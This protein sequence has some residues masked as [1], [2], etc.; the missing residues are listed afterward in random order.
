M[1]VVMCLS[2]SS[3][4]QLP[5]RKTQ[6]FS[7]VYYQYPNQYFRNGVKSMVEYNMNEKFNLGFQVSSAYTYFPL[8]Y[9]SPGNGG[10][11]G[12]NVQIDPNYFNDNSLK[13]CFK[14]Y[15]TNYS[16]SFHGYYLGVSAQTGLVRESYFST[17]GPGFPRYF[18][19]N[20]YRYNRFAF[21]LGRQWTL[22]N[23]GV[24]D[25]NLGVGFN[26]MDNDAVMKFTALS[27]FHIHKNTAFFMTELAFGIGTKT[28][29]QTLPNKPRLRDSL[30]LDEALLID[31]NAILNAGIELNL[32]HSNVN[33]R[34]LRNYVRVRN[35][36][37][38]GINITEADSF[39]SIMVGMQ[40]RHYPM[41]TDYR[42]GVYFGYGYSYEHS[43]AFYN[44]KLQ[45]SD[46]SFVDVVKR[47]QYD[48][49]NF[50]VTV[51][52]TTIVG[53]RYILDGYVS[54]I[55]T[56]SKGQGA[57]EFPRINDA[58]GFRTE[59]G[60]KMGIARFKRK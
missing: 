37:P 36:K 26:K 38:G 53:H 4:G 24:V 59:L 44:D 1:V 32:Y 18:L 5:I 3:K 60:F 9:N 19:F 23:E 52:F 51:G 31:F 11:G 25:F 57:K 46:M 49:H 6:Q 10:G 50:D 7:K 58:T 21:T 35:S 34:M 13:L 12:I 40:Y 55:L 16:H 30:R 41:A 8:F 15:I 2:L 42:N 22:Y 47:V 20:S 27:P 54:N 14:N 28:V 43:N 56:I 39:T 29:D 17:L 45:L 48:P 33:K